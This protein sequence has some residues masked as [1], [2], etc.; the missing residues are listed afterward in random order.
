MWRAISASRRQ[1]SNDGCDHT[2]SCAAKVTA[3][4]HQQEV[5]SN[6]M[7][8][9]ELPATPLTCTYAGILHPYEQILV[10]L[11][12]KVEEPTGTVAALPAEVSV[13][14]GGAPAVSSTQRWLW[15][16]NLR[17]TDCG[18]TNSARSTRTG[19]RRR[20]RG[21]I[22]FSSPRRSSSTRRPQQRPGRA[23]EGSQLRPSAG[24]DRQSECDRA[25]HDGELRRARHR[26][27]PMPAEFGR[28]GRNGHRARTASRTS[29]HKTVPVFNL[30]P[31][32]G[33]AGAVWLRGGRQDPDRHRHL[34]AYGQGLWRRRLRAATPPR[35]LA[36]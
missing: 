11:K 16:V 36:C 34:R 32:P 17:P 31:C 23:A 5:K 15:I 22:R 3:D 13:E 28:R 9:G 29:S 4:Q 7:S 21:R 25:V 8:R 6:E 1:R 30:V 20:R 27:Q 18:A 12:V 14:G 10:T 2:T 26:S 19:H 35:P 24:S 33:R